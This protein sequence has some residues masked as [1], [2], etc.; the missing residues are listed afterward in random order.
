MSTLRLLLRAPAA[1]DQP[2]PWAL[3]D[4][5]GACLDRGR[6]PPAGWPEAD[7]VVVVVGASQVRLASVALPPIAPARLAAAAAFALED[8]IANSGEQPVL[9]ASPQRPDGRVVVAIV[10]RPVLAGLRANAAAFGALAGAIAEPELASAD[11]GW[12]WCAP[13]DTDDGDGFVRLADGSA[14]PVGAR[15][16]DGALP[17]ELAL[18]L[19]Q[20]A[21]SNALPAQVRVDA[22][23]GEALLARWTKETNV[24]FVRGTPWQWHAAPSAAYAR[25]TNLLQGEFAATPPPRSGE[26]LRLFAPALWI[27]AAALILHI[28]ATFGEW[29]WWRIDAW[30]TG[31]A[32]ASLAAAAGANPADVLTPASAIASLA[33]TYAEQRHAHG[34]PAPGDALPLLARAAPALSGVPPGALKSAAYADGHWTLDLQRVDAQAVRDLEVR[35]RQSG[36]PAVVAPTATGARLRLSGR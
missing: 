6:D 24:A 20:A 29:T 26:R 32:L 16:A 28:T 3:C 33:R 8:Q 13:D 14:F 5:S 25:A 12:C 18:A 11:P 2:V 21:R 9:A 23:A 35:L 1:P 17:A 4:A 34:L 22:T 36:T 27:A 7:R 19:T 15:S 10:A 30:R 31:R